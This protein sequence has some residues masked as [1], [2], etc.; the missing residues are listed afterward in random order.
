MTEKN[1][2]FIHGA[3]TGKIIEPE[4]SLHYS[5]AAYHELKQIANFEIITNQINTILGN[6]YTL[7]F[8][9]TVSL[10]YFCSDQNIE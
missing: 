10:T 8:Y 4:L 1:L 7:L 6:K 3:T 5:L 2:Q 9:I